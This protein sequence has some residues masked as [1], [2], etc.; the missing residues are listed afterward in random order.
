MT[1]C[2]ARSDTTFERAVTMLYRKQ[3]VGWSAAG[4]AGAPWSVSSRS[5]RGPCFAV[6]IV[7][8]RPTFGNERV[9]VSDWYR[10]DIADAKPRQIYPV[11]E[12]RELLCDLDLHHRHGRRFSRDHN[13]MCC[14]PLRL[15]WARDV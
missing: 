1:S 6:S 13:L 7:G 2:R 4:L 5:T 15:R 9:A 14:I 11:N 8:N 12:I 10:N 3:E